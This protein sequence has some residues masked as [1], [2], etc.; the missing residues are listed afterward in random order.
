MIQIDFVNNFLENT[1]I[2]YNEDNITKKDI[3]KKLNTPQK[4]FIKLIV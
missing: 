3:D 2:L 1:K 4:I